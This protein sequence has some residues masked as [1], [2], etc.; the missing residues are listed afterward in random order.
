MGARLSVLLAVVALVALPASAVA[1]TTTGFGTVPTQQVPT[2][3]LPTQ[4]PAQ[5]P[6]SADG[7]VSST[8]LGL[9]A[10]GAVVLIAGIWVVIIRDARRRVPEHR[11]QAAARGSEEPRGRAARARSRKPSPAE[12]RRR[13]RTRAR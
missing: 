8:Q 5:A 2:P 6:S 3:Q 13:K 9:M 7:G 1:G 12:R 11:R 4:E 10:L